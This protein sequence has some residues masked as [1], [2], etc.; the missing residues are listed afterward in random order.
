[1]DFRFFTQGNLLAIIT[2]LAS[3]QQAQAI[4]D[5]IECCWQDLVR[6]MP[7]KICFPAV[8]GGIGD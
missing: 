8:E 1:M 4:M 2:S 5:L 6:Q 7:M 3:K